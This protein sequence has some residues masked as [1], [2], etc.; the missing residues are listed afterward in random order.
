MT[1][2]KKHFALVA[3]LFSTLL[4]SS[5]LFAGGG[6]ESPSIT[7]NGTGIIT[8]EPDTASITLAVETMNA[9]A[10]LAATE[11]AELMARVTDA[12]LKAGVAK[13]DIATNNYHVYQDTSYNRETG[14][15][16][17]ND[18]RVSNNLDITVRVID[19]TGAVIDAALRAG[20]NQLSNVNFYAINTTKAYEEA[21]TLAFTHA[22]HAAQT[23]ADAAERTLG[24][25]TVIEEYN[26]AAA[27]RNSLSKSLVVAESVSMDAPT[28]I[29]PGDTEI[30][31]TIRVVFELK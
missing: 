21:R 11:N 18:Y 10:A 29:T 16:E 6:A 5:P 9:E 4:V 28:S 26:N 8:L 27:Y 19:E 20:A 25:A 22:K 1:I 13:E 23:F 15:T 7:V 31:V 24:K 30:S 2:T 14:K 12:I 17:Y 3:V